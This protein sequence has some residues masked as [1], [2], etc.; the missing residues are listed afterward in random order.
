[1]K[2]HTANPVITL[3]WGVKADSLGAHIHSLQ[4]ITPAIMT[5]FTEKGMC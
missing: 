1:V 3:L 5:F 2:S 4:D